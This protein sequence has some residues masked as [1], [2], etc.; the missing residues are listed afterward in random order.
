MTAV[1]R[2][3]ERRE[4]GGLASS[5]PP[6]AGSLAARSGSNGSG[7]GVDIA[8]GFPHDLC[9]AGRFLS[10]HLGLLLDAQLDRR[11]LELFH[12]ARLFHQGRQQPRNLLKSLLPPDLPFQP[13]PSLTTTMPRFLALSKS[14][15]RPLPAALPTTESRHANAIDLRQRASGEKRLGWTPG[16]LG[17]ER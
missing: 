2:D 13:F 3:R 4:L 14:A 9:W 16:L 5:M 11:L 7:E 8:V 1:V 12:Q 15:R 10:S 6:I 17:R